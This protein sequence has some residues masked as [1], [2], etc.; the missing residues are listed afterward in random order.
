MWRAID[1]QG[2]G[3][4]ALVTG[5]AGDFAVIDS[6]DFALL[7]ANA[8]DETH[9]R[10]ADLY[11]KG[12]VTKPDDSGLR[13]LEGAITRTRKSFLLDGPSLHIFVVTLR[14]DH[15]CQYCQV[16]RAAVDARG[17]DM[18]L[19]DAAAAVD[20][21]FESPAKNLTI[22]FQ[23]GE[24]TLRF[25]LV[26]QIVAMAEARDIGAQRM[27]R[28]TM[29]T[30]LHHLSDDDLAFCHD[31]GIHLSTS[32]DGAA[33][34]HNR[35]RSHPSRQSYERTIE[36]LARA[37]A[38]LGH[39]GVAALPTLTKA[40]LADP[41][42]LID[43]Y[44]EL[45]FGALFLRPLSPYGFALK[46]RRAIGYD[47]A[48]FLTFYEKALD[49]ILDLNRQG[50][51]FEETNA[52][53]LLR[54]ILTPFHSGYVDLR[55]PAGAGLGVLVYNYDGKVYPTDEARM[56][57]ETGDTR[58]ALGSVHEP[59]DT[60]IGSPAMQWL[61]T[62]AVAEEQPTC[63]KCA[64]VPYCGADPVHH[65]TTQGDPA[66][67]REGSEFCTKHKGLFHILFRHLADGDP[68][69]LRTFTAWAL[70]KPRHEVGV[71]AEFAA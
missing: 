13:R 15:S 28:F 49:R 40:T 44:R 63:A 18:N 41:H 64:F 52:A 53:I 6:A 27:M 19:A 66:A 9:P 43:T 61:T 16:S 21:V 65:A 4:R 58:F 34:L 59:L 7:A 8:L 45:G 60:L 48:E 57:A 2:G 30:T 68:E 32:I 70:R 50:I 39:D 31:H 67:E 11:A 20:R 46:T 3:G 5:N 62:G 14:C 35:Q 24:P 47:M 33:A 23:G 51:A 26:R 17:Y 12:F 10:Y 22:E 25:D 54:H 38:V 55:S 37:R 1:L 42:G 36:G 29:A 71:P 69:T 56:A